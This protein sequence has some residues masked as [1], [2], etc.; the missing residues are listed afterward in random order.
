MRKFSVILVLVLL[1][2]VIARGQE[3][4][5]ILLTNDDGIDAD[6]IRAMYE[7]LREIGRVTVSAP[8]VNQSGVGHAVTLGNNPIYVNSRTDEHGSD[9]HAVGGRPSDS[10][11][12]ALHE[13]LDEAPDIVV[14]GSNRGQNLGPITHISGT[15]GAAREATF[16][17][18]PAIAVS[19]QIGRT[20]DY[21]GAARF[22][23][24]LVR[25]YL[26]NGLPVGSFISV[27]YPALRPD[28]IKGARVV[29]LSKTLPLHFTFNEGRT[30]GGQ[31]FFWPGLAP[32]SD[33][34]TDTDWGVMED[35]Y[36][37]VTPMRLDQTDHESLS[38]VGGWFPQL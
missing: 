28:Q 19:L 31:R 10:V 12:L 29:P 11:R 23:A 20:M 15:L 33:I 18:I 34:E 2:P 37:A 9:W 8:A 32:A 27:N 7:A 4:P 35:A 6:G 17:G 30:P 5:H 1:L 13:L 3:R 38:A 16:Y 26:E 24:T 25:Q 14:S 36:I 22:T 21:E